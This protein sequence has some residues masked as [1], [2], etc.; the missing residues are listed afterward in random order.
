M[1]WLLGMLLCASM[2]S[3]QGGFGLLQPVSL[4][5]SL[6][7]PV[8]APAPEP[9]PPAPSAVVAAQPL[10]LL[11]TT[12]EPELENG[13]L[14]SVQRTQQFELPLESVRVSR[15]RGVLS[16]G[17]LATLD[18]LERS[19]RRQP[20]EDARFVLRGK[21]WVATQ[22]SAWQLDKSATQK[23]LVAALRQNLDRAVAVLRFSGQPKRTV[24]EF[25][26][27]GVRFYIGGGGSS[28]AGSPAFR[29]QNIL[30][31]VRQLDGRYLERGA[32]FNF[33]Q[34]IQ[35][36]Q[37]NGYVPGYV[38]SGGLLNKEIGGGICQV[39]TTVW[40]AAY[41][42]GL[43]I[44]ER[45][46][47]SYAVQYYDPVGFEA[48]VFAPSKNLRFLNDTPN[49]LWLQFVVDK[50]N[51]NLE[52][53]FFGAALER[54]VQILEPRIGEKRPAPKDRF[55]PD[56]SLKPGEIKI[57]SGAEDGLS[58]RYNRI[59]RYTNGKVRRDTTQSRYVPWG[60]IYA[61]HPTDTRLG[62]KRLRGSR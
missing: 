1:R 4:E 27:R 57:V 35:I 31:A 50:Q 10:M 23:A 32:V 52:L 15:A 30:A 56:P 43:P 26:R 34:G 40:R 3:A 39:S 44:L 19:L 42:A 48:T 49:R 62:G 38:I 20:A 7:E 12:T 17:L 11:L 25:V 47:H 22:K 8:V 29:E 36:T 13:K 21:S 41:S 28:Y 46:Q 2:V 51:Q 60:A 9:L 33:N 53:H 24:Q 6:P 55:V 18:A 61:V 45:H 16:S 54:R 14:R 59:V 58:V 5:P 37:K